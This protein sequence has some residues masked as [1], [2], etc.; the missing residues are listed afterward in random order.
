MT[1]EKA[2]WRAAITDQTFVSFSMALA[3]ASFAF[4]LASVQ[5]TTN[6]NAAGIKDVVSETKSS[7]EYIRDQR[8]RGDTILADRMREQDKVLREMTDRLGRI[9]GK[10]DSLRA[11]KD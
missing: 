5:A 6:A 1:T 10:L 3:L 4:W 2:G 9:E 8:Q 7:L 11:R